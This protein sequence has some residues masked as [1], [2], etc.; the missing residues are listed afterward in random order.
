MLVGNGCG[1]AAAL[2]AVFVRPVYK[3]NAMVA[4]CTPVQSRDF[5]AVARKLYILSIKLCSDTVY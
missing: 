4:E 1:M 5:L 2:D 3:Q